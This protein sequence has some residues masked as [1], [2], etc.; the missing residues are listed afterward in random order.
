MNTYRIPEENI[1]KL[2]KLAT[3]IQNKCNKFGCAFHYEEVGEEF[4]TLVKNDVEYVERFI[5]VECEGVAEVNGWQFVGAVDF[6]EHGNVIRTVVDVDIPDRYRNTAPICEH[7]NV[8]RPRKYGFLVRNLETGEF[9]QVGKS[10]LKDFTGGLSVEVASMYMSFVN[11]IEDA[12]MWEPMEHFFVY[13]KHYSVD[14]I[15][16]HSYNIVKN[17]GYCSTTACVEN[18]YMTYNDSTKAK[19]QNSIDYSNHRLNGKMAEQVEAFRE[20]YDV[21]FD[22]DEVKSKIEEIKNAIL[23][24][25]PTSEYIKNIQVIVKNDYIPVKDFGLAVSA[26]ACYNNYI[27]KLERNAK[28]AAQKEKDMTSEFKGEVGER[29]AIHNLTSTVITGWDNGYGGYTCRYKLVDD[30]NN[31]YMW[32]SSSFVDTNKFITTLKGTVKKHDTYN[33]V[34][35]TWLTRCKVEYAEK[36][37]MENHPEWCSAVYDTLMASC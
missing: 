6:T 27:E 17:I 20:K 32:D 25:E 18:P 14:T 16:I 10:C 34:N 26:I 12:C 2:R 8:N 24:M 33:G 28:K 3:R 15:L 1:E 30:N 23:S 31:I 36:E 22:S 35:Q 29:V 5:T 9:K 4:E 19:V 13:G 37:E 11:E 21:D 7:C